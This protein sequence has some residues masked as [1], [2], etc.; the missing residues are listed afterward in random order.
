MRLTVADDK[1]RG[2]KYESPIAVKMRETFKLYLGDDFFKA[3]FVGPR[4]GRWADAAH[5][6]PWRE[7][8]TQGK[9]RSIAR[10]ADKTGKH[11]K[12]QSAETY[13]RI[14]GDHVLVTVPISDLN[15]IEPGDSG[16]IKR[17]AEM[18]DS[19]PPIR[20]G[21]N[22]R[23]AKRG[24]TKL[25]VAD[26]N[27]RVAAANAKG[28]T[29]IEA[30]IP[31]EDHD[32]WSESREVGSSLN[33]ALFIGPR[34]GKWADA[35]HTVPWHEEVPEKQLQEVAHSAVT[36]EVVEAAHRATAAGA[37]PKSL[38]YVG[39][40]MEG[41][42]FEDK[43]GKAHKVGRP[44][45]RKLGGV[46]NEAEA[47]ESLQGTP[48]AKFIPKFY[49][50]DR[51]HDV[52]VRGKAEGRPGGWGTKGLRE[53]YEVIAAEL[54]KQDWTSPEFK[55]DSF[56][57]DEDGKNPVMVD[58]G[59]LQP[60]G[61]RSAKRM[62]ETI[63]D[64]KGPDDFKMVDVGFEIRMLL[65]EKA[66]TWDKVKEWSRRIVAL[67]G[68]DDQGVKSYLT[69]LESKARRDGH[70][71]KDEELDLSKSVR[72]N[73][74]SVRL[75]INPTR[76]PLS[77]ALFIGPR[78]GRWADAAHTVPWHEPKHLG[79]GSKFKDEMNRRRKQG[80]SVRGN[81]YPY[82]DVIKQAGG[83]WDSYEKQWLVPTKN[84]KEA[85]DRY[86][87]AEGRPAA[88]TE[89]K[90]E[91][92]TVAEAQEKHDAE[93]ATEITDKDKKD[94]LGAIDDLQHGGP[95]PGY[96][97]G[98]VIKELGVDDFVSRGK[99]TEKAER[100]I[101]SLTRGE[102]AILIDAIRSV[103]DKESRPIRQAMRAQEKK[104]KE[105]ERQLRRQ[106]EREEYEK[107]RA[108][109]L[110]AGRMK[111]ST[112]SGYTR[113]RNGYVKGQVIEDPK[114][115]LITVV[116][117]SKKYVSEDG[118]S[119]GVGDDSGYIYYATVR[120]ATPEESETFLQKKAERE[121]TKQAHTRVKDIGNQIRT[122]GERPSGD[123]RP[124]GTVLFESSAQLRLY[125]GG[126]WYVIEP[127]N[128]TVWFVQN[129]GG[130]GDSWANNNVG[131]GGAGAVGWRTKSK[132]LASELKEL[133]AKLEKK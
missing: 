40:G 13:E 54:K 63:G 25:Y 86:I 18:G 45:K 117:A 71:G 20:L 127:D 35:Q 22:E 97:W 33:K 48:A 129:N 73:H 52:L 60:I 36:K 106:Q 80:L 1:K 37:D 50:Y 104:D 58:V 21:Y 39:A 130:D 114:H 56:I 78:G 27:H 8:V 11:G 74:M 10:T 12:E 28:H 17:Y 49:K 70:I 87:R 38:K 105:T 31:V 118:L 95:R 30:M 47:I 23:S 94:L 68:S 76:D 75:V 62:D 55:E 132:E 69:E 15:P 34:G 42:I 43:S 53:A 26:G 14:K 85:L 4:G 66:A 119:F 90:P 110:D 46:R 82:K 57:V 113:N 124:G 77:K 67:K 98:D 101:A 122:S 115:G 51:G 102:I 19:P 123:N 3:M 91:V 111:I 108:A 64:A 29:H 99:L 5:T 83:I 61:K 89:E 24:A 93:A 100:E 41:I 44:S 92:P 7:T 109:D 125:G 32:R 120:R 128:E 59:L 107:K 103:P 79:G 116:S 112:G 81:T 72:G 126:S 133:S 88:K 131:T 65:D 121:A 6:I 84:A 96:G 9:A 16:R 2:D